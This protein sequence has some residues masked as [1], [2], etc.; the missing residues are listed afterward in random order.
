MYAY[1][2]DEGIYLCPVSKMH[3]ILRGRHLS[4]SCEDT[5]SNH[6]RA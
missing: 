6:S 1:L 2:I 3:R 4:F 5:P